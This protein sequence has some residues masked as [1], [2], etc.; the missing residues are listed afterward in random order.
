M[1]QEDFTSK[2]RSFWQL[3]QQWLIAGILTAILA[4]G[5]F[6]RLYHLGQ[7]GVNEY[8][9]S[10]VKSMLQSWHN[11]F[12]VAFEPGGTVSVDK[13]PLGFW[14]EALSAYLFGFSGFSLAL[15]NALAGIL[16]IFVIYKL[17]RRPFGSW[18]GLAAA[19]VLAMMPVAVST[20]RNNTI[21]GM[22]ALVV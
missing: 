2:I 3:H 1:V 6:L 22:L 11:F 18:T 4:A 19:A 12:Y 5:A 21:D 9:A 8:Y 14:A 20:E 16:S 17:V 7:V 15:P 10:A 13:P